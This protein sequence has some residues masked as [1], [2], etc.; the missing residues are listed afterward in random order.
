MLSAHLDPKCFAL[1]EP[2]GTSPIPE[3]YLEKMSEE[4]R[5]CTMEFTTWRHVPQRPR[6]FVRLSG[7]R[8]PVL[9]GIYS[10]GLDAWFQRVLTSAY[11]GSATLIL[12]VSQI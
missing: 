9:G 10:T 3:V 6:L 8:Q 11:I 12:R 1:C 5:G 4:G 2:Q 7:R